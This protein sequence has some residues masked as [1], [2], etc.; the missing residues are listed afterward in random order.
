VEIDKGTPQRAMNFGEFETALSKNG[1]LHEA[2]E[3]VEDIFLSFDFRN[4][5]IL[6]RLFLVYACMM[7]TLMSIYAPSAKDLKQ[8]FLDFLDADDGS[9][10][11]RWLNEID[12]NILAIARPYGLRRLGQAA[13]GGYAR[14]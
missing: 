12:P 14:F 1:P 6:G 9:D 10:L 7:H 8:I 11:P 5:P 13:L 3:I 2:F 4:R